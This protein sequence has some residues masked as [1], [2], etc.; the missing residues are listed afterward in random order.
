MLQTLKSQRSSRKFQ[1]VANGE[2]LESSDLLLN[3][4]NVAQEYEGGKV[5]SITENF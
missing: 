3:K 1:V 2:T 4:C 5:F